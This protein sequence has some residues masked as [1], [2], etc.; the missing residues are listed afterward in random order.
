[1]AAASI[2]A[3]WVRAALQV[4]PFAYK[5]KNQPSK[6]FASETDY[7]KALL[8]EC[9]QLGIGLIA[10]T[11]HWC[12]DSAAG[13]IAESATRGI[14]ALP[15]FEAN[16][17]E[18]VHLLVIFEVGTEA[19]TINAAIGACGVE[20]GCVNGTT[21]NPF[22][23]VLEEMSHRGA[24][25]IPAHVNVAN[26][27][28]LTGRPGQPLVA[29]VT[30]ENLHAIAITPD[31]PDAADQKKV[32]KNKKPYQRKHPLAVVYADDVCSPKQ[33]RAKGATTWFKVSSPRVE[34]LKL[35][36]R[37]PETRVAT[38]DPAGAPRTLLRQISWTGGFLDGV[39]V[40]ISSDLTALIGGRGTGKST[41]IESLRYAL[42]LEPIG[43]D[44]TKDHKAI[45]E[46]VVQSGT[47]IRVEVETFSPT[48]RTFTIERVVPDPPVV[49][50]ASGTATSQQ[51]VDVAGLVEVFGQ[52]EL[53]ELAN[54]PASVA[55]MVQRFAGAEGTNAEHQQTLRD[56]ASNREQIAKAEDARATL[57]DELAD[58]PRLEE[59]V[60]QFNETDVATRLADLKR[61][62]RDESVFTEAAQ[63]VQSV[64]EALADL[65]DPQLEATLTADYDGLDESP[66]KAKLKLA[67]AAT[68]DLA[69]KLRTLVKD[70]NT[71]V[72]AAELAISTAK[73][74][75]EAAVKAQREG[76]AEVLEEAP[77]RRVRTR[78]VPRHSEGS[79]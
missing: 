47:I 63:R 67:A 4:N 58:I 52:H 50:D 45:V 74:D 68:S 69:G 33:L 53:A 60:Q 16:T 2:G 19:S 11:D 39:T 46:K 1:M 62:D 54:N 48:P 28:L 8:D 72:S 79:R 73:T 9:E 31:Q 32:V 3:H 40:P 59:Q 71:A 34:S 56:L 14:V 30:D 51:P 25:V 65:N 27:G 77:R 61:L 36:V 38:L 78:Q 43:A 66:Q 42:G 20:P 17:S 5:G 22:K 29:M 49:L 23:E 76:H 37:T 57:E 12:V 41:V 21:G 13:L 18:G 44:A 26:G 64:T 24:L 75:W 35:A 6:S 55:G 15:G 70:A 7:N 10:I